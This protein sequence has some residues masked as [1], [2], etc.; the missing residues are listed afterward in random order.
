MEGN[1]SGT[2]LICC[3][4]IN[5]TF[6]NTFLFY[7]VSTRFRGN[8]GVPVYKLLP[9]QIWENSWLALMKNT[10]NISNNINLILN[11]YKCLFFQT[12]TENLRCCSTAWTMP[13]KTSQQDSVEMGSFWNLQHLKFVN[14]NGAKMNNV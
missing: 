11:T 2:V 1:W 12:A 14:H 6:K 7:A 3:L 13:C 5:F 8:P 9:L 10:I 4:P